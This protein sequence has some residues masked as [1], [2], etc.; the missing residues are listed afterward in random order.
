MSKRKLARLW[1]ARQ[2]ALSDDSL[3]R[4]LAVIE[5]LFWALERILEDLHRLNA[6]KK[7]SL[8][9]L[10]GA[11]GRNLAHGCYS[12]AL[13][14]LAQESGALLRPLLEAIELMRYLRTVPDAITEAMG[15]RLPRAGDRAKKINGFLRPIREYLN[16]NASHLAFTYESMRHLFDLEGERMRVLQPHRASVLRVNL[17][18]LYFFTHLLAKEAIDCLNEA[19][20]LAEKGHTTAEAHR[21]KVERAYTEAQKL[22]DF[23]NYFSP[24]VKEGP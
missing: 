23:S 22:F 15:G 2:S 6:S 7:S 17:K 21:A 19:A 13:D 4:E 3:S 24:M 10:V 20:D 16:E 1:E 8:C 9:A 12:L 18:Q 14:G 11:K 5:D